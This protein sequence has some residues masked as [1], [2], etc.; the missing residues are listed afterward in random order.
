M[1]NTIAHL[2]LPRLDVVFVSN[3]EVGA[4][5]RFYRLAEHAKKYGNTVHWINGVDGR[6][7]ALYQAAL[8]SKTKW[9]W[10]IPAK[11]WVDEN[12]DLGWH[13]NPWIEPTHWITHA[14]NPVNGLVYGHQAAV[15]YYRQHIIDT[16]ENN[17]WGLDFTM[18]ASHDIHPVISG[19]AQYNSDP[20]MTWR[21][22]FREVI[23]LKHNAENNKDDVESK[24]R[25]TIW[26]EIAEGENSKWSL[27]GAKDAVKYY[28]SACNNPEVLQLSFKWNWLQDKWI[29]L[30]SKL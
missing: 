29:E 19:I 18:S 20:W 15:C 7:N 1:N 6:E 22:A 28:N 24:Q 9:W 30:N 21:T 2:S 14:V 8:V 11:L 26:L 23:K 25:L 4:E 13:P 16:Y 17:S 10:C 27:I 5:D 3:G 12:F